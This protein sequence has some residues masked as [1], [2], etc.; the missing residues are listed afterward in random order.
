[1]LSSD[2]QEQGELTMEKAIDIR[3]LDEWMYALNSAVTVLEPES[4][5]EAVELLRRTLDD[6]RECRAQLQLHRH[7]ELGY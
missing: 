2:L 7:N 1:M 5:T 4:Q 3:N 6:M